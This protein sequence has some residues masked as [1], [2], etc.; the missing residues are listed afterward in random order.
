VSP[1]IG[2]AVVGRWLQ[3]RIDAVEN[4]LVEPEDAMRQLAEAI[5]DRIRR[6]RERR[7]DLRRKA[8]QAA[9]A[10]GNDLGS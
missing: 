6:N 8:A 7:P 3:E 5:D 10:T 2:S 9:A 4:G 1:Y